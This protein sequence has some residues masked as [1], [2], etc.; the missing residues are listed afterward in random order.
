MD[1]V[2]VAERFVDDHPLGDRRLPH[3]TLPHDRPQLVETPFGLRG[4]GGHLVHDDAGQIEA[5]VVLTPDV[6]DEVRHRGDAP[7]PEGG[8]LHDDEGMIGGGEPVRGQVAD[9]GRAIEQDDVVVVD[10]LGQR[11]AEPRRR[12]LPRAVLL[13]LEPRARREDVNGVTPRGCLDGGWGGG[14]TQDL[15]GRELDLGR[16][17]SEHP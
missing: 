17:D 1:R 8:G 6:V 2:A 3:R 9:R 15:G 7:Q 13:G 14:P 12:L 16:I 10:H 11:G 5:R 4:D